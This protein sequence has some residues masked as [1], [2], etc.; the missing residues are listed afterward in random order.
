[1]CIYVFCVYLLCGTFDTRN[2]GI[3]PNKYG[4]FVETHNKEGIEALPFKQC[5]R[6]KKNLVNIYLLLKDVTWW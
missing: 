3:L 5:Q 6:A 4:C 1:M 2:E